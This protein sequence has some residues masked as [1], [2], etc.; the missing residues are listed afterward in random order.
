MNPEIR[1]VR[2]PVPELPRLHQIVLPTPWDVGPVQVYLIEGDPLTLVDTG[3]RTPESWAALGSALEALGY[4]VE[5]I[6]RIVLTHFHGDHLGQAQRIRECASGPLEVWAHEDE[7]DLCEGFSAERDENIEGTDALFALFGVPEAIRSR[8][9]AM[10]REWVKQDPLCEATRVDRAL[11]SGERIPFKDFELEV[12]HAPGHTAGHILLHE[13]Q[14]G[15]LVTGDHVMGNAVPYTEC[16][17]LEGT[18]AP[19]DPLARPSCFVGLPLYMRSLRALRAGGFRRILPA[20][21]GVIER[22]VQAIDAALLFYEVRVQRIARTLQK[23]SHEAGGPVSAWQVWER[24]FPKADPVT[25]MR[26]RMY[27][28]IGGLAVLEEQGAVAVE[29]DAGGCL[30][31]GPASAPAAGGRDG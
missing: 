28:V 10:R 7:V 17:L 13:E 18:P 19:G 29:R 8:Q 26:N 23:L 3:V 11:R 12:V 1:F 22:A 21:G 9:V 2:A 4:G 6:G 5:E 15:T 24:L 14:T 25:Q 31:H 20:H 27:M 16:F 30:V